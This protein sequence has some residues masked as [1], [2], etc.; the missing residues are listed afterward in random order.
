MFSLCLQFMFLSIHIPVTVTS[1]KSLLANISSEDRGDVDL[2]K[3]LEDMEDPNIFV[4]NKPFCQ[5]LV[6]EN[7]L[8]EDNVLIGRIMEATTGVKVPQA[9][10]CIHYY[11]VL[12]TTTLY[13]HTLHPRLPHLNYYGP[14]L[15]LLALFLHVL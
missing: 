7:V 9:F 6:L 3:V 12:F 10:L 15:V 1:W 2:V 13:H 8:G 14:D 4:T 11:T 5:K